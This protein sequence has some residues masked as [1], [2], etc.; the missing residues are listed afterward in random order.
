MFLSN[1]KIQL[2]LKASAKSLRTFSQNIYLSVNQI[3]I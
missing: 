2:N 3:A 1:I